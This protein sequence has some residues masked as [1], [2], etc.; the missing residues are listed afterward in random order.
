MPNGEL[1][2]SNNLAECVE[3]AMLVETALAAAVIDW[4]NGTVP[5]RAGIPIDGPGIAHVVLSKITAMASAEIYDPIEEI[6]ITTDSQYHLI[7]P[8]Q[9]YP[10]Y[11]IYLVLDKAQSNLAMARFHLATTVETLV[12]DARS[13]ERNYEIHGSNAHQ[14]REQASSRSMNHGD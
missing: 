7:H 2:M 13:P 11:V 5:A 4:T 1:D 10:A 12:I 9:S 3:A 8:S 14:G 6:L